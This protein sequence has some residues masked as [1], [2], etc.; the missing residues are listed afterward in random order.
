MFCSFIDKS[1]FRILKNRL[2]FSI[3]KNEND[4]QYICHSII[5]NNS[6]MD[7]FNDHSR[8]ALRFELPKRDNS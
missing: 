8:Q 6:S 4:Y 1:I 2:F 7:I 3:N 5:L